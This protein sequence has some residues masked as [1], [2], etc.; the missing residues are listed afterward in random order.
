MNRYSRATSALGRL[1]LV[2][3]LA[4]LG[5][6]D[7]SSD[8]KF[9]IGGTASGLTGAVVLQNNGGDNL[10]VGGNGS[11]TF[12][13]KVKKG[14]AYLVTIL[15]KPATQ[16]CVITNGSGNATDN[17]TNVTLTCTTN[18]SYTVGGSVTG[19]G[20]GKTVV[21][22]NN[23]GDDLTINADGPF[24]FATPVISGT[25]YAVTVLTQPTGQTC[26][27]TSGSG[28]VNGANVN[29]V[30]VNCAD[31][32]VSYTVGGTITGLTGSVVL[33]IDSRWADPQT[34]TTNGPFTFS[35]SVIDGGSYN[36][37]VV[38]QPAGR[39]CTVTN[40]SGAPSANVTNVAVDC[41]DSSALYSVGGTITGL[42]ANGLTLEDNLPG[43]QAVAANATTFVLPNKVQTNYEYN[44]GIATQP[45]GQ[46]CVITKSHGVVAN[47]DVTNVKVECI[48]NLTDPI[49]GTYAVPALVP[50]SYVYITFFG[51]GVYVYGSVENNGT[52]CGTSAA[53][54][55]NGVEYGVYNY[56]A[57]T[58]AFAFKSAVVD[59]NGGCGVWD[60]V[61]THSSRFDGTLTI[62]NPGT[63]SKVMTLALAGGG[64]VDLVPV[65]PS[66]SGQIVGG[67]GDKYHKSFVAFLSAGGNSVYSFFAESQADTA[68]PTDTGQLAGIEYAC[69]SASA[70]TGGNLITNFTA[71]CQAP[72]PT[73]P[74]PGPVDTNGT[75]GLSNAG[76]P[77]AFTVST[78]TLT[79]PGGTLT[80]IKPN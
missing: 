61:V 52:R 16:T 23:G 49:V 22:R 30:A 39:T 13:K 40:G 27:V 43:S 66:T 48:A 32:L 26:T 18:A 80:R 73:P 36:V 53:I 56:N 78:D 74:G 17:V 71:T 12:S 11:F 5:A 72:A 19:L 68:G 50:D 70:L 35:D 38:T 44:V 47:A 65:D 51:D 33:T 45:T 29:S 42:T 62:T 21:L 76:S 41:V 34:F 3:T 55:G 59:T 63:Q 15:S 8:K 9:S 64:S 77:I 69:A 31:N 1:A 10:T 54:A 24:T 79:E 58:H 57:T 46:T 14:H 25:G 7:G 20:S 60:S 37:E 67:W 28:T 6:C 75:A 2:V 4:A